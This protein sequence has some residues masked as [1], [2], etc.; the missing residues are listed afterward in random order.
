[1]SNQNIYDNQEFFD[2]YKKLRSNPASANVIVEKPALFSLAP[3]LRGKSVLDLGCGYG[4]NCVRF[5]ELGARKVMGLDISAKMLEVARKENSSPNIQYVNKSMTD[6]NEITETF[7]VVFSSLAVHYIEDFDKLVKDVYDHL[8][9]GGY[10]IFSQ[11]HP[12]TTALLTDN[13]WTRNTDNEYIHY[14]LTTYSIEGERKTNWIVN[15]VIKYHRTFSSIVN[16]L[17][18]TGFI[19]EKM[20][21][22][23]PGNDIMEQYP[24]YKRYIHKPDFLLVK[25]RKNASH[26]AGYRG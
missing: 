17:S 8:N 13:Y 21:E 23:S 10:F 2:G 12:L 1:M 7:D 18:D 24:A 9:L 6:L 19:I 25:A 14:N 16:T 4:E 26:S 3:D 15:G 22:P 5:L 20:L 11:E